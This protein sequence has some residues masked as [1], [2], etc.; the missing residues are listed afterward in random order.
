MRLLLIALTVLMP[1]AV[2]AAAPEDGYLS[3]RNRLMAEF[4]RLEDAEK[5]NDAALKREERARADLASQLAGV[6]GPVAV[7]GFSGPGKLAL[8][9]L[10]PSDIGAEQLDGLTFAAADN[11][12]LLVTTVPLA[13]KWLRARKSSWPEGVAA[14]Q[15]LD[16]ALKLPDFYTLA[17]SPDAAVY[18]FAELPVA[19][20]EGA[21]IVLALLDLRAQDVTGA[22]LPNEIIV[23]AVRGGRL[24]VANMPAKAKIAQL[25]ACAQV[26]RDYEAKSKAA[27]AAYKASNGKD[28]KLFERSSQ[29]QEEGSKAFRAC[30]AERAK[31]EAFFAEATRQAQ[32]MV[33]RMK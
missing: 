21:Q 25:P 8:G 3:A 9:S 12:A 11:G 20:P 28:E 2:Q 33:D 26:W 32:E 4:K 15:S 14:P 5:V 27:E 18:G 7:P 17:I 24:Y 13:E 31:G 22:A 30:F 16:A 29:L 1:L 19:R 6:I 23:A 10:F